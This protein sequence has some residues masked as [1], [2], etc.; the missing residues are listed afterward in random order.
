MCYKFGVLIL[1]GLIM[2]LYSD[3]VET[4]ARLLTLPRYWRDKLGEGSKNNDVPYVT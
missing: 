1:R 4:R 3:F 2:G